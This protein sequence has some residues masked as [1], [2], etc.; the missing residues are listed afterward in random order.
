MK[1][2]TISY[3]YT[4]IYMLGTSIP[5]VRD[6]VSEIIYLWGFS[7][8]YEAYAKQHKFRLLVK[9]LK[10]KDST[11]ILEKRKPKQIF[12]KGFKMLLLKYIYFFRKNLL[13]YLI[14]ILLSQTFSL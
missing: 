7:I 8:D 14:Q 3:E 5:K 4:Y 6:P 11:N 12:R 10:W 13:G 1:A 9:K 2:T